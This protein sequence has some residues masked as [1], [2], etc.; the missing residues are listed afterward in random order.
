VLPEVSVE[1]ER[2]QL[3]DGLSLAWNVRPGLVFTRVE[4]RMSLPH[5]SSI[6]AMVD[7]AVLAQPS[8]AVVVHD[9][10]GI[11][12]YEVAV[13]ARMSAWSLV[14]VRSMRRVVIGASSPFVAAA[15][16]TVNLAVGGRFELLQTREQVLA[17]AR[18]ELFR[19]RRGA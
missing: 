12:S 1:P 4:G 9:W 13:H 18:E 2:V 7:A 19:T 10:T 5:A 8:G 14:V 17:A 16:R 15:V 3:P 11:E 6:M